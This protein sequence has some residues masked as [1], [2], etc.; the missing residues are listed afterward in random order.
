MPN[1]NDSVAA[2]SRVELFHEDDNRLIIPGADPVSVQVPWGSDLEGVYFDGYPQLIKDPELEA[3]PTYELRKEKDVPI[4]LRDGITIYGD[5]YRPDTDDEDSKF[6]VILSYGIWGKD[7]QEAVAWNKDKPQPYLKSAFWDGSMEAGDYTYAVPRGYVHLIVDPRGTGN[8]E[9]A[10]ATQGSVHSPDDIH[11]VIRWAAKQPWS[12]GKVGM[13]GPSS[14]W[15]SQAVA[16]SANPPEE[17]VAIHPDELPWWAND[18][19]HGIFDALF[20]HIEF[21]VHG[22]DSTLP[23]PNRELAK[24]LPEAMSRYSEEELKERVDEILAHP[25][26]RYNTKWYS[27]MKYP[28]KSPNFFDTML[29][30]FR[31]EP[32]P[33]PSENITV[34]MYLG[35]PWGVRL[36]AWGTFHVWRRAQTPEGQRKLIV[37]PAGYTPRPYVD[38]HDETIR[39]YDYW[40]KGID[41]GIMD[42]PPIKLFVMGKNKWRF[43]S[44][45]PLSRTEWSKYYLQPGGGLSDAQPSQDAEPEVL[46]SPAAY[47]TGD[48]HCLRY[49]TEPFEQEMEV[50]G[51]VSLHLQAAIDQEDTNWIVDLVD[52]HPDGT[53]QTLTQGFLKAAFRAL[54]EEES[55]P[56][57]PVHPRQAPEP[58]TP[59]KVEDYEIRFMPTSNV[60]LPGHRL[61][62]TVRNQDDVLSQLGSWGVYMLPTMTAVKHDIHFGESYLNLP[63]IPAKSAE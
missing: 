36:Y 9:G 29:S 25:D 35:V 16:A 49:T 21:G 34:P 62:L 54:D 37:Y 2:G 43:E 39:W 13:M 1:S 30:T 55:R 12:N 28:M 44:E 32:M 6:P 63:I 17:L 24:P 60:F 31:P 4:V 27:G 53:R 47:E 48:V 38:F 42:E 23:R 14:Y 51:P 20:Y 10:Y 3:K 18:N 33:D 58:V 45:W 57:E 8:S 15:L 52:I 19:H 50:T 22:N 61:E 46:D 41:N 56:G 26:I 7:A 40:A 59:G 11:D 5:V